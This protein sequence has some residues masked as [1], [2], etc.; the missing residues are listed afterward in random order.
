[1]HFFDVGGNVEGR[2]RRFPEPGAYLGSEKDF[3]ADTIQWSKIVNGAMVLD[4]A[5]KTAWETA[6][7]ARLKGILTRAVNSEMTGRIA[8]AKIS[9]G[10]KTYSLTK[11]AE[12]NGLATG[13]TRGITPAGGM[14]LT[15]TSGTRNAITV[16]DLDAI[17]QLMI[18]F[19][20][21][22]NAE[23]A[24][25]VSAIVGESSLSALQSY[26]VKTGWT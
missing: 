1:M 15:D 7:I 24:A 14:K 17:G 26:D 6:E 10:G 12:V 11:Q 4:K 13:E 22:K 21:T 23:E 25:H 19:I 20:D 3:K 16:A 2:S 9:H 5:A 18:D 8:S